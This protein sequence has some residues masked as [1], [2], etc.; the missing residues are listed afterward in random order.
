MPA[1]SFTPPALDRALGLE[2]YVTDTPGVD[3][4]MKGTPE[5]FRVNE[6]S[7]YPVPD[8]SGPYTV[9]RIVSREW[10]QHELSAA[11]AR[12]I[13]LPPHAIAWSGT[14]DR[15]A[16]AER[17]ASYRGDPPD[18]ELGLPGVELVEAYRAR[19]GLVLGHHYG[20]SFQIHVGPLEAL[21][22]TA[23][24]AYD[25][26]EAALRALGGFPN[27]FGPQRFGEVRPVTHEV[28]RALVRGDP[29]AAVDIYLTGIPP[30][31]L[32][33]RGDAARRAYAEHRDPVRALREM[34]PDYRFERALLE[35][36]ARGQDARQALHGLSRDL[37][38][39]FVH[40]FQS[41]VFNRWLSA[42]R[43]AGIS[44]VSP[45]VGDRVLRVGRDG[46]VRGTEPVPVG[47]DNER[48]CAELVARGGA[49]VAGPLVGS[50]TPRTEGPIGALLDD[51]LEHEG[52][53][54]LGFRIPFAP[55]ISSRGAWR[56]VVLP[57][58]P[59]SRTTDETG[60]WFR[61]ALP[62]GAYATVLLREFLKSGAVPA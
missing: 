26:T 45:V 36:L 58:P 41:F 42:R 6:I 28:G 22:A 43:R 46:T 59:I 5:E 2:F 47:T 23:Q 53:D 33:G 11:L 29:Q 4:A 61:F 31:T 15:R 21:R 14:K 3:A 51:L 17:L 16:V 54:R 10:E 62:K 52:V 19:D 38:L 25:A 50:D 18:R 24:P 48:E 55:E 20:N 8:P 34:P 1:A 9:L 37:R 7:S 57:V 12:R 39:L 49:W 35:R 32:G 56:P 60:I 13:G 30:G 27:F 44:L 40:A